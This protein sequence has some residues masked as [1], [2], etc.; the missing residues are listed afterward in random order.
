MLNPGK[1]GWDIQ[2]VFER[3]S[4]TNAKYSM[5]SAIRKPASAAFLSLGNWYVN[6][7]DMCN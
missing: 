7:S 1:M 6:S 2:I 4:Q 5:K 3:A